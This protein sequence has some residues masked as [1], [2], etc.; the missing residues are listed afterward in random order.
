M[1]TFEVYEILRK[2][3]Q[4]SK[5]Y[6]IEN[7]K[8]IKCRHSIPQGNRVI[9]VVGFTFQLR[10]MLDQFMEKF[11]FSSIC[12]LTKELHSLLL[13]IVS[14]ESWCQQFSLFGS[15]LVIIAPTRSYLVRCW[16]PQFLSL[17]AWEAFVK[18][19]FHKQF[20]WILKLIRIL[21]FNKVTLDI[22][23]LGYSPRHLRNIELREFVYFTS[24][25][26]SNR[27]STDENVREPKLIK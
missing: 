26:N 24:T 21:P 10:P 16:L 5:F 20:H 13:L 4:E 14:K 23:L 18:S 7:V 2:N 3:I 9:E 22:R 25:C 17:L 1:E 11:F 27:I 6:A 12:L 8:W 19:S 15:F